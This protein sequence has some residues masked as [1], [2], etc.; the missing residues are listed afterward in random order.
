MK[1]MDKKLD[2]V[3]VEDSG[4][5]GY[6]GRVAIYI[7]GQDGNQHLHY[8][9][10]NLI[11]A[12]GKQ[13]ALL[14][15]YTYS[16]NDSLTYAKVGTGGST[17]PPP[18]GDGSLLKTPIV[19]LTDLYSPL[20][21]VGITKVS[22]DLS[23]PSITLIANLDNSQANGSFINEAGF[24]SGNDQMFNIKVFPGIQKT[25]SFSVNFQWTISVV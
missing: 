6:H 25:W 21:R 11:V 23:V 20:T 2:N 10:D 4:K 3:T 16:L 19:S 9:D 12:T 14:S 18:G 24:F 7:V 8:E 1:S 5:F 17:N 13:I 22:Q 15:L